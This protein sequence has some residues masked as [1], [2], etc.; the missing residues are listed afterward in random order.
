[1]LWKIDDFGPYKTFSREDFCVAMRRNVAERA[2]CIDAFENG[3]GGD[4]LIL[5]GSSDELAPCLRLSQL[6]KSRLKSFADLE[7][8]K[9]PN[10]LTSMTRCA[11]FDK[12]SRRLFTGGEDG[13][14]CRWNYGSCG[15]DDVKELGVPEGG[16][17]SGGKIK[18]SKRGKVKPY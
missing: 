9:S 6:K 12:I 2:Y 7:T 11:S 14:I 5:G 10:R 1:M 8:K 18:K 4:L 13:V 17:G 3:R 16:E 15:L